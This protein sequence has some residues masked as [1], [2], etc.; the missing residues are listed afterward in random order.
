MVSYQVQVDPLGT[1]GNLDMK[2]DEIGPMDIFGD[3]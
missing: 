3:Y 2:L 1:Y